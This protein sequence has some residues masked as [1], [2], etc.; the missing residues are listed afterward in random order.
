MTGTRI[1]GSLERIALDES[2]ESELRNEGEGRKKGGEL[3]EERVI[4]R[5]QHIDDKGGSID[6][7]L[8]GAQPVLKQH[9]G[10]RKGL[11]LSRGNKGRREDYLVASH[12]QYR[13]GQA[14][15]TVGGRHVEKFETEVVG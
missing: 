5:R 2:G 4:H 8:A 9:D 12:L 15:S 6:S 13:R 10:A 7:S 3:S 11:R 14:M 1:R